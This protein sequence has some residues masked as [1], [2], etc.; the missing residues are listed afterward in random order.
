MPPQSPDPSIEHAATVP[1]LQEELSVAT[2]VVDTGRGVRVSKVVDERPEQVSVPL[3]HEELSVERV[4]VDV[5]LAEPP[6]PRY[7]G[8]TLVMPVV[9]EV[10]VLQ[11]RYRVREELR[12]T[13]TRVQRQ[14]TETVT[15]RSEEV[16]VERFDNQADRKGNEP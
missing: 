13:R 3:W 5:E 10:V 12:I 8:D 16:A 11:K 15:L 4:A 7:E 6:V 2:R 14:H 1:R 9:E